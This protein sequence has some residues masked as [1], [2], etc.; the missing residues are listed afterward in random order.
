VISGEEIRAS[1]APK[2]QEYL[3]RRLP[4]VTLNDEQGPR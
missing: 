2:L 3:A 4:G 1:G